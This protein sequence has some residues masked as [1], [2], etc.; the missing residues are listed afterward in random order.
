MGF[1]DPHICVLSV[2]RGENLRA[3]F[4]RFAAVEKQGGCP[5]PREVPS[6]SSAAP[7]LRLP[8]W[9][10][11]REGFRPRTVALPPPVPRLLP[12]NTCR[13]RQGLVRFPMLSSDECDFMSQRT[14]EVSDR[15]RQGRW[16]ARYALELPPNLERKSGAAVR[17]DRFVRARQISES[18]VHTKSRSE[19]GALGSGR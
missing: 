19:A 14:P 15:R 12:W 13:E 4:T 18:I 10:H 3:L 8:G 16:S 5:Y 2:V 17:L 7:G 6:D 9:L 1:I 11:G